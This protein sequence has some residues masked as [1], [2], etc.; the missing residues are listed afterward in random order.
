MADERALNDPVI[1]DLS[2]ELAAVAGRLVAVCASKG[3]EI[4]REEVIESAL[5]A[6]ADEHAAAPEGV[7]SLAQARRA[8]GL[9]ALARPIPTEASEEIERLAV[10]FTFEGA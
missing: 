2:V 4:T 8:R 10:E 7:I 3:V 6:M 5:E 9:P 1:Y